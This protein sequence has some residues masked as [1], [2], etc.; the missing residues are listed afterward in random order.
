MTTGS[1]APPKTGWAKLVPELRVSDFVA[2]IEP[3]RNRLGFAL[4]YQRPEEA[5]A[6]LER[7]EGAQIM[8]RQRD[9]KWETAPLE[10]SAKSS[11][12]TRTAIWSWS[13]MIS[14]S[15]HY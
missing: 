13:R 2:S 11:C 15:S 5:F 8:L 10:G 14:V 1:G 7:P 12:W 3:W 6:Y 9:G 4:T